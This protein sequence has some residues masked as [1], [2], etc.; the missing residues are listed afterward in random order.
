MNRVYISVFNRGALD[1]A[2]N[3]LHSLVKSGIDNYISYV[4][5]QESYD[6]LRR[7]NFTV[8]LMD[9]IPVAKEGKDFGTRDFNQISYVRYKAIEELLLQD[10]EVWYMDVDTVVLKNLNILNPD[11]KYDIVFQNDLN[12]MCTGC[13]LMRPTSATIEIVRQLAYNVDYLNNDQI[14]MSH[15]LASN[16]VTYSVLSPFNFP[17]GALYFDMDVPNEI[18]Q[19]RRAFKSSSEPIF[20]VHANWMIGIKTK[21]DALKSKGLWYL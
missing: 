21:I 4:T 17:N 11:I 9:A 2:V 14:V 10:K 15:L 5:D 6:E 8:K 7:L 20:F 13:M 12:M 18:K 1:L 16:R 19:L 3:H